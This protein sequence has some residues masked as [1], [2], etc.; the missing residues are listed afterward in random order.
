MASV[1]RF[2][3]S[4]SQ[5]KNLGVKI[6]QPG[7]QD[8]GLRVMAYKWYDIYHIFLSVFLHGSLWDSIL[9]SGNRFWVSAR[10]F[11]DP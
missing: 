3:D 6:R 7:W 4:G 8:V 9:A 10:R 2:C 1:S 5:F 11:K